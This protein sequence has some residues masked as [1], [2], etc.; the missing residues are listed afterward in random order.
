MFEKLCGHD[1]AHSVILATTNWD[2]LG[3]S[4]TPVQHEQELLSRDEYWG[5]MI[6]Y[7][8]AL[9][10]HTG[11]YE[12]AMHILGTLG[13]LADTKP[14]AIDD[15]DPHTEAMERK[16]GFSE[17]SV[18]FEPMNAEAKVNQLLAEYTTVVDVPQAQGRRWTMDSIF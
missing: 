15:D 2:V 18:A 11:D 12:S 16:R 3:D 6:K 9:L 4:N 7:G 14:V 13:V 1:A 8:S 10:R 5:S 17:S